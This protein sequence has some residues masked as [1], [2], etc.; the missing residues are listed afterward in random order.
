MWQ[1]YEDTLY[2]HKE[3]NYESL[4]FPARTIDARAL[5]VHAGPAQ[6]QNRICDF[7]F[8]ACFG[9][10]H[11]VGIYVAYFGRLCVGTTK[12]CLTFAGADYFCGIGYGGF[13]SWNIIDKNLGHISRLAKDKLRSDMF[14]R[15]LKADY[16]KLRATNAPDIITTM[17][18]SVDSLEGILSSGLPLAFT[19]I[20]TIAGTLA[21][22]FIVDWRLTLLSLPVYPFLLLLSGAMS[23]KVG[24]AYGNA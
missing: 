13:A 4:R 7:P 24:A 22:M 18:H 12:N 19:S 6:R 11:R 10:R 9:L 1:F 17:N 21:V 14:K 8:I 15:L 2:T 20:L 16:V 23:R 5:H 3:N